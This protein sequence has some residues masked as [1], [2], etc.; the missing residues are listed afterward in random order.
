MFV[1]LVLFGH[2][3]DPAHVAPPKSLVGIVGITGGIGVGVV[4]PVI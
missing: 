4:H 1:A 3:E 2:L